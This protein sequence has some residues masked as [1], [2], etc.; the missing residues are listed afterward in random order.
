MHLVSL[1]AVNWEFPL[2]GRTRMLTESWRRVGVPTTFVEVPSY[3]S[4]WGRIA[5]AAGNEA[6]AGVESPWPTF[7]SRSWPYISSRQLRA[8]IAHRAARLHRQ[9]SRTIEWQKSVAIIVSPLWAPWL[10]ELPFGA[11]VYDCIDDL[12]VHIPHTSLR[13]LYQA[14]EDE[15]IDRASGAVVSAEVLGQKIRTRRPDLEVMTIRNAVDFEAFQQRGRK[16]PRP[17]DLPAS[18]R[19]IVGFVGA[20]YEWLDWVLVK[21][22][23]SALPEFD[24]VFVGPHKRGGRVG[25]WMPG[26][27]NVFYMGLKPYVEISAWIAAFDVCWVPFKQDRIASSANPVKIYEYLALG[28]PVVSTPIADPQSFAG[29]VSFGVS[30]EEVIDR[31]R[32]APQK[33]QGAAELRAEFARSNSWDDRATQYVEFAKRLLSRSSDG[34]S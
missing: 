9:L 34:Q 2:V 7:P 10:E 20:L 13:K 21:E 24:F 4:A 17:K 23:A 32:K 29:L 1:S 6:P 12:H 22:V 30:A 18:G 27:T 26:F 14:W 15:L 5:R 8:S 33:D 3:R 28:K 25:P 31:L 11:V 19:P 16:S